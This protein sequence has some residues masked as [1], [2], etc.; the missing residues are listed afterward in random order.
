MLYL[1]IS[2]QFVQQL[3]LSL[4]AFVS[5][6]LLVDFFE[7]IDRLLRA[8]FGLGGMIGYFLLKLPLA[9][10]QVLPAA[11]LLAVILTFGLLSRRRETIA[12]KC[13]GINIVQ[14]LLP[15]LGLALLLSLLLG[16]LQLYLN[17]RLQ[18]RLNQIWETQVEKKPARELMDLK[19]F[20]YK[21]D[22][23]IFHI[24]EFQK[25]AK[26]MIDVK[27]YAFDRDFHLI[28]FIAARRATWTGEY[29]HLQ[30]GMV[31]TFLA[32]GRVISEAFQDRNLI[33]TERPEDFVNLERRLN[34]M[35]GADLYRYILRLERDGY[36]S[37][38]QW[39]E[40]F[41][42]FS[43]ALTP[44]I[45]TLI[46]ASLVLWRENVNIPFCLTLGI[47]LVFGYWLLHSFCN[48][49]GSVGLLPALVA[50]WAADLIYA[51]AGVAALR[52]VSR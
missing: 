40:F 23:A 6:Y 2:R 32:G 28:Q 21:G 44:L 34:E 48:S 43:L 26:I 7:K 31:Q 46:G 52:V 42:R 37:T 35:T 10:S 29:W 41:N 51:L 18:W 36:D 11:V 27:I 5:I 24:A 38:S 33:L 9:L 50:A 47:G 14:L 4:S 17:P 19:S 16:L 30:Q 45:V 39:L 15:L 22:R 1:Y 25:T 8:D 13:A 12:I 49:L 20:W 3:T